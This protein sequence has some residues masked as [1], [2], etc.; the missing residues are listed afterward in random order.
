MPMSTITDITTTTI[1]TIIISVTTEC[2]FTAIITAMVIGFPDTGAI[3]D[4]TDKVQN[5]DKYI[6]VPKPLR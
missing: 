6:A 4:S 2:G 1:T 5:Y 3:A